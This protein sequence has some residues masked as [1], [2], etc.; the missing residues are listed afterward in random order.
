MTES[1]ELFGGFF[2]RSEL[3][4]APTSSSLARARH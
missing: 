1:A 3:E 2:E 4:S